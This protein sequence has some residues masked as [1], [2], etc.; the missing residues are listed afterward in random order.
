MKLTL[1]LI[2]AAVILLAFSVVIEG[3]QWLLW[4]VVGV[5]V[6]AAL[7]TLLRARQPDLP[8]GTRPDDA[9]DRHGDGGD[10]A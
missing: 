6:I 8:S 7:A 4:A 9:G 1:T 2:V 10:Q 5:L 3:L